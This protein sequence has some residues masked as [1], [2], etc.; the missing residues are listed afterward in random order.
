LGLGGNEVNDV[1]KKNKLSLLFILLCFLF[2]PG[3]I[4]GSDRIELLKPDREIWL[5]AGDEL[6]IAVKGPE[7][8]QG[9]FS[10]LPFVKSAPLCEEKPG[11]FTGSVRIGGSFRKAVEGS[12]SVTFNGMKAVDFPVK[13]RALSSEI[14]LTGVCTEERGVLRSGPGDEFDR[15][16][17]LPSNVNVEVD[18]KR[19]EWYRIRPGRAD[20]WVAG[21][22]IRLLPEGARPDEPV[23]K[24]MVSRAEGSASVLELSIA[25]KC[26]YSISET[27]SPPS[28]YLTLYGASSATLEEAYRPESGMISH[29]DFAEN[30]PG[31]VSLRINL[32][33]GPLWGYESSFSDTAFSLRLKAPPVLSEKGSLRGLNIIVDPGHGGRENGAVGKGGFKEKDANLAIAAELKSLLAKSGA[34]V[35]LTR[36]S[37]SDFT[38]TGTPVAGELQ[39]RVDIAKE[40]RGD[41]FVSIHNNAMADVAAGRIAK[42]TY[43]YYYHPHS[44]ELAKA[45]NAKLS[46]DLSEQK[47]GYVAR[48]FHVIRQPY[49]PAVLVEV[50]FIS[51]PAEELKLQDSGYV[52]RAA[53]SIFKGIIDFA[54]TSC[55]YPQKSGK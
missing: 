35:T 37:D 2:C 49:M 6:N 38:P 31:R 17:E 7:K 39:A 45:I 46:A 21:R 51:N 13:I 4:Q 16:G 26:A 15:I 11:F 14:P 47:S 22:S 53:L 5:K 44:L 54:G 12:L 9:S 41:L 23:L 55:R 27:L 34:A 52:K 42:G 40:R 28:L 50:T 29:I 3:S 25:G 10:C 36:E 18:G 8:S 43:T 32:S 1:R 20:F 19:G 33:D 30:V 48:S 24:G